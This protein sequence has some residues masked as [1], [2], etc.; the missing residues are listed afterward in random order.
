MVTSIRY[1]AVAKQPV[2]RSLVEL[3]SGVRILSRLQSRLVDVR[4]LIKVLPLQSVVCLCVQ[5][6][7]DGR[8]LR[9]QSQRLVGRALERS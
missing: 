3:V 6:R 9:P 2:A 7:V 5:L 4:L 8:E 1:I